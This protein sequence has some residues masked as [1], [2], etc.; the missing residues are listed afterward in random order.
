[1]N[2]L[3]IDLNPD[4]FTALD[5]MT[6]LLSHLPHNMR[7]VSRARILG[8]I[9]TAH[10]VLAIAD[11]T[12][13]VDMGMGSYASIS[14]KCNLSQPHDLYLTP[15]KP[16]QPKSSQMA[17]YIVAMQA[18]IVADAT[19]ARGLQL[20]TVRRIGRFVNSIANAAAPAA[21]QCAAPPNIALEILEHLELSIRR[22]ADNPEI[23][24]SELPLL[25]QRISQSIG[26][27]HCLA[28]SA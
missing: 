6:P 16:Y 20:D 5:P 24:M 21:L 7:D 3:D 18:R 11:L 10:Q 22:I 14:S 2:Y 15:S 28:I 26:P 25:I 23:Q 1:M 27:N 8:N 13:I 9:K 4:R 12:T 19:S 17:D